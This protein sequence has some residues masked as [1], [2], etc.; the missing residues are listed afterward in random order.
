MKG[1]SEIW[2]RSKRTEN[3]VK[4]FLYWLT[5]GVKRNRSKYGRQRDSWKF[6]NVIIDQPYPMKGAKLHGL[7]RAK[8][9]EQIGSNLVLARTRTII[10]DRECPKEKPNGSNI[11]TRMF[12]LGV[13]SPLEGGSAKEFSFGLEIL[14]GDRWTWILRYDN[15]NGEPHMHRRRGDGST[16]DHVPMDLS[17][18]EALNMAQK[19][20]F[21]NWEGAKTRYL[22]SKR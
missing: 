9:L 10:K 17:A 7:L 15:W 11:W 21:K 20:V 6:R 22:E 18:R 4:G 12:A 16:E 5:F 2:R 13:L 1:N 3:G 14:S 8:A 19:E